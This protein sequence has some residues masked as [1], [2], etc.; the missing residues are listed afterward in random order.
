[1]TGENSCHVDMTG[2][3]GCYEETTGA[4]GGRSSLGRNNRSGR[5]VLE[6]TTFHADFGLEK[7]YIFKLVKYRQKLRA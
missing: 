6:K 5:S 4:T 1:M 7:N 2:E 3:N